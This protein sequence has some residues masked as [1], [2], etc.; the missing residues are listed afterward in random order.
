MSQDLLDALDAHLIKQRQWISLERSADQQHTISILTQA[1]VHKRVSMGMTLYPLVVKGSY[2]SKEEYP[3]IELQP[4]AHDQYLSGQVVG[5]PVRFFSN[6]GKEPQSTEG[7]IVRKSGN[8]YQVQLKLDDFPEWLHQGKLGLDLLFD[9]RPYRL[10]EEALDDALRAD[11]VSLRRMK[12]VIS[13]AIPTS[14]TSE[15]LPLQPKLNAK[16]QKAVEL[17]IKA[18]DIALV[19]G[20]PGTGKT[21]VLVAAIKYW[22]E[23]GKGRVLV[24]AH[25]NAAV[26]H[27][28]LQLHKAGVKVLRLGNPGKVSPELLPNTM[29]ESMRQSQEYKWIQEL[30]KRALEFQSM[31]GKY[32]RQFG[33]GDREQR[34][35]LFQE[36]RQLLKEVDDQSRQLEATIMEGAQVWGATLTGLMGKEL[37][38]KENLFVV[39]DEAAQ[40]PEAATWLAVNKATKLI[41]AGDHMQLPPTIKSEDAAKAGMAITLFE[42]LIHQRPEMAVQLEEQYRMHP[43]IMQFPSNAFYKKSLLAAPGLEHNAYDAE[44]LLWLDTA[45]TGWEEVDWN[46]KICNPEEGRFLLRWLNEHLAL[47]PEEKSIGIIAPY[48][49]QVDWLQNAAGEYIPKSIPYE[50]QTVDSFQGQ[51]RDLMVIS[52]VRSNDEQQIGFLKDFRRLNVAITRARCKVVLI[53]DSSTL[54]QDPY[55]NQLIAFA[56]ANN[57]AHSVWEFAWSYE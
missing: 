37:Q 24:T 5:A 13:G 26:D 21:T 4:A 2:F 16:Q 18:E 28:L 50:I 8:Q 42:R 29:E 38:R 20:P 34:K 17:I 45:G 10:M 23:Q 52:L 25:S 35:L 14:F 30:R 11:T 31:A 6:S 33:A 49:G 57:C 54:S 36:S 47:H 53:G 9:D 19:H 3:V 15:V 12:K 22:I 1:S 41:M 46:G 43:L 55:F 27:L 7:R 48:R 32:K 44:P 51:E 39:I 40:A 56:E